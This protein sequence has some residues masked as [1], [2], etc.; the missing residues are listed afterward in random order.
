MCVKWCMQYAS[1]LVGDD[2]FQAVGCGW[3]ASG[4]LPI[5]DAGMQ[6]REG[7]FFI[8]GDALSWVVLKINTII[9]TTGDAT[10]KPLKYCSLTANVQRIYFECRNVASLNTESGVSTFP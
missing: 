10:Q 1:V 8:S 9:Y 6:I 5:V 2:L 4:R 7:H 3:P